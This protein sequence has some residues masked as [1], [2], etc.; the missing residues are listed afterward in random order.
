[1]LSD[2][3]FSY[4]LMF[5]KI[6]DFTKFFLSH[7]LILSIFNIQFHIILVEIF[8]KI[9]SSFFDFFNIQLF[10]S[11]DNENNFIEL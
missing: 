6:S 7:F 2:S 3:I 5:K 8:D 9:L 10:I 1:M 4:N 11:N